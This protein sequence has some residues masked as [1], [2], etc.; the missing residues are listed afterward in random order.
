MA[1]GLSSHPRAEASRTL[2]P[3]VG[4]SNRSNKY[5]MPEKLGQIHEEDTTHSEDNGN[6][7]PS[8]TNRKV[9]GHKKNKESRKDPKPGYCENCRDKF[10]DFDEH[11]ATRKHRKFAATASNWAELDTVLYQLQQP[12]K[13]YDY[14]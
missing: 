12:L 13:E 8:T 10:D 9:D 1:T 2:N 7:K 5:K 11:I 3:V 4:T 14:V 6:K